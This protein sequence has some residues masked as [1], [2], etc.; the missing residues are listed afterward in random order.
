MADGMARALWERYEPVHDL[1]YFAPRAHRAA[2]A[3]GLRGYWMGYFALRAAP[4]GAVSPAVVTSSFYVFHPSRVARALPDAWG[5]AD[6]AR[7]LAAREDAMDAAMTELFGPEVTGSA[8][9]TEAADL[10]WRAAAAADTAG[11]VLAAANQALE[12]PERP[13]A[14]LWQAL[15]TLREHRGDG[16]MAVLV[17]QGLGPVEAMVLKA[18]AGESDEGFLRETRKWEQSEWTA[19][20]TRLRERGLLAGDGSLTAA[21]RAVRVEVEALTDAAAESPWTAL[22]PDR[23][24]RLAALLD[25]LARAVEESDLLPPG[26]PVGLPS[27]SAPAGD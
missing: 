27:R 8:E 11:R 2:E 5:Y 17:G 4:L 25:P 10:A 22:G 26:N 23:T 6:P 24:A 3:L 21:G 1:V 20:R 9:F 16:H 12:R 18:A 14:R 15:T 7:V 19:A 13:T